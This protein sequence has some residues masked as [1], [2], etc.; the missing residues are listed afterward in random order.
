MV[1]TRKRSSRMHTDH[2]VPRLSSELVAMRPTVDRQ[3]PVKTLPSLAVGKHMDPIQIA[4][5]SDMTRETNFYLHND[6]RWDTVRQQFI[7]SG[8]NFQ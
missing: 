4:R 1:Q 5:S 2:A 3:T 8:A 6:I 7:Q